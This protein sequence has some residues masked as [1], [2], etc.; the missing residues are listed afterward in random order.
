MTSQL[1]QLFAPLSAEFSLERTV[2]HSPLPGYYNLF[3]LDRLS[4]CSH[5]LENGGKGNNGGENLQASFNSNRSLL[6][7]DLFQELHC[8]GHVILT[9]GISYAWKY[10]NSGVHPS[11]KDL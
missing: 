3:M 10:L 6:C 9:F 5:K 1:P 8:L 2:L 7:T 11:C 4:V